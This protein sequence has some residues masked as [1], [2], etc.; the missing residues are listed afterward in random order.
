MLP[1]VASRARK[2][3][4]W[5]CVRFDAA[6]LAELP[7]LIC[8]SCLAAQGKSPATCYMSTFKRQ[9]LEW[10]IREKRKWVIW[11]CLINAIMQFVTAMAR[12]MDKHNLLQLA[13]HS[14]VLKH[15]QLVDIPEI[16]KEVAKMSKGR[17]NLTRRLD[18]TLFDCC[19]ARWPMR[20]AVHCTLTLSASTARATLSLT[21]FATLGLRV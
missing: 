2:S 10:C 21:W 3:G 16:D 14:L 20:W 9:L 19:R 8:P 4:I 11:W 12:N 17:A 18:S 15:L 13:L 6:T 5:T 1:L 7:V